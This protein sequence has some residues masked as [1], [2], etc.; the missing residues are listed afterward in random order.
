M[1][2]TI[3][4]CGLYFVAC[5]CSSMQGHADEVVFTGPPA[6]RVVPGAG[7]HPEVKLLADGEPVS[8]SYA[9]PGWADVNGDGH[10][11]LLVGQIHRGQVMV[12]PGNG[13][14]EFG[15]GFWLEAGGGIATFDSVW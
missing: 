8:T 13:L 5:T 4:L 14:G 1:I 9:S 10:G 3:Y 6:T 7:L 2:R 11:D 12:Y 15:E